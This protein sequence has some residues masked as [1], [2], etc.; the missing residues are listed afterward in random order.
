MTIFAGDGGE[1]ECA[2]A[3]LRGAA[4]LVHHSSSDCFDI[5]SRIAA[6]VCLAKAGTDQVK[7]Y[8][9]ARYRD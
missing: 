1:E 2:A 5:I 8:S 3:V 9:S 6:N 7:N 4:N